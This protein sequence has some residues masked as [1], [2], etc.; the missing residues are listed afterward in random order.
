MR[1]ADLFGIYVRGLCSLLGARGLSV[2]LPSSP[3]SPTRAT[4]SHHG[5]R[6]PVPELADL[7]RADEFLQDVA[8][9]VRLLREAQ[10]L[11]QAVEVPSRDSDGRL[12]GLLTRS[13]ASV[14]E[15]RQSAN[16]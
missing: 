12:I 2:Y 5:D 4:L 14:P 1:S 15:R 9:E 3:G 11:L 13:P 6:A 8:A 7:V 16:G 10:P